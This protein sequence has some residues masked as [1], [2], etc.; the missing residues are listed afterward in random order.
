MEGAWVLRG[1]IED[2]LGG[3]GKGGGRRVGRDRGPA[4][5]A[6]PARPTEAAAPRSGRRPAPFPPAPPTRARAPG[7][8]PP[9]AVRNGR[10]ASE[11]NR[12][13]AASRRPPPP[14]FAGASPRTGSAATTCG[15]LRSAAGPPSAPSATAAATGRTPSGS[16]SYRS[17]VGR[18]AARPGSGS[19][20]PPA[21]T[22]CQRRLRG[23]RSGLG[24]ARRRPP[25]SSRRYSHSPLWQHHANTSWS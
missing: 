16:S 20:C 9:A 14:R 19:R 25:P 10:D 24:R 2:S 6:I 22:S 23:V 7:G 1:R 12:R 3:I 13:P 11:R 18:T 17:G 15:C 5:A 21:A 8:A 4:S